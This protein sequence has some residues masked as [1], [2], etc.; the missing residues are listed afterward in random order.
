MQLQRSRN[1]A[2]QCL[3]YQLGGKDNKEKRKEYKV[4]N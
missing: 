3:E 4:Q 1:E 2:I